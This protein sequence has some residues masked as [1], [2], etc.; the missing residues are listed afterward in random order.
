MS[1]TKRQVSEVDT[2]DVEQGLPVGG[3]VGGGEEAGPHLLAASQLDR[4][5]LRPVGD[6]VERGLPRVERRRMPAKQQ[7]RTF[8]KGKRRDG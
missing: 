4:R 6:L 8:A 1:S 3:D 5:R 7:R 2:V